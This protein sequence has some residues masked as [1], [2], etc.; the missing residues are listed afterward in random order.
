[1]PRSFNKTVLA[2]GLHVDDFDSGVAVHG[3][4]DSRR[5]SYI[6]EDEEMCAALVS[7]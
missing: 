1:M 7:S 6:K 5:I 2:L 3:L 4:G